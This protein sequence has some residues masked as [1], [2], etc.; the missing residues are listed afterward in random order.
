[1]TENTVKAEKKKRTSPVNFARQVKAEGRKVTWPTLK[2]VKTG[3]I[4]VFIMV[5]IASLFLFATDQVIVS[6]LNLIFKL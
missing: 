4:A 5:T 1:M 6:L 3:T 2:E